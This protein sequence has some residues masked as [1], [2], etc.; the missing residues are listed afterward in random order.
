MGDRIDIN[1]LAVKCLMDLEGVTE[2]AETLEKVQALAAVVFREQASE[3]ERKRE[4]RDK[5]K[6]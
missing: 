5:G 4:T 6:R 3:A 2:Q 1:I